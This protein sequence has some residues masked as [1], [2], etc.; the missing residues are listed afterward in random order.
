M[1]HK[2]F[3]RSIFTSCD[4]KQRLRTGVE[5]TLRVVFSLALNAQFSGHVTN[6]S[7]PLFVK[8]H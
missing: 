6:F 7:L 3:F 8:K 2:I 1:E 5:V 4:S